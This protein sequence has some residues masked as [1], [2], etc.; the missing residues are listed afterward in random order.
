MNMISRLLILSSEYCNDKRIVF[1]TLSSLIFNDGK[2]LSRLKNGSTITV[3]NYEHAVG[4]LSDHWPE[5]KPWP[6]FIERPNVKER[7]EG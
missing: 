7:V 3:R 2:T 4:W 5:D 1:S 6:D